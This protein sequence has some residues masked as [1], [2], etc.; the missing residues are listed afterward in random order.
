MLSMVAV[1]GGATGQE[2]DSES[3]Q[4]MLH[5]LQQANE[6]I[7]MLL[8]Q[9]NLTQQTASELLCL[10]FNNYLSYTKESKIDWLNSVTKAFVR[11]FCFS[12][13]VLFSVVS[14]IMYD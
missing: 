8:Q 14:E 4:L 12:V 5:E 3:Y 11:L 6:T 7:A 2:E 1:V 10:I 13:N 9:L